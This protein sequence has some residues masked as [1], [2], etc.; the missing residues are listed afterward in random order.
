MHALR[1][2]QWKHDPTIEEIPQP[3]PGPGQVLVKIGVAGAC[4][5]VCTGKQQKCGDECVNVSSDNSNCGA[6]GNECGLLQWCVLGA[7][8]P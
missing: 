3:E 8:V 5:L 4:Q 2:N 7:C 6:C 1:L